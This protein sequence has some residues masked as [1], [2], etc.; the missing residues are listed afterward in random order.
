MDYKKLEQEY[1]K[2]NLERVSFSNCF[3][4]SN[5]ESTD[6]YLYRILNYVNDKMYLI[7]LSDKPFPYIDKSICTDEVWNSLDQILNL[8]LPDVVRTKLYDFRWLFYKNYESAKQAFEGYINLLE[9]ISVSIEND[10]LSYFC[11]VI[12]IC[13]SLNDEILIEKLKGKTEG[14]IE[15]YISAKSSP[16]RILLMIFENSIFNADEIIQLCEK[17]DK[18]EVATHEE[19]YRL[20]INLFRKSKQKNKDPEIIAVRRKIIELYE[21]LMS[22]DS[23]P[24]RKVYFTKEII[25]ELKEIPNTDNERSTWRKKLSEFQKDVLNNMFSSEFP[26]DVSKEMAIVEKCAKTDDCNEILHLLTYITSIPNYDTIKELVVSSVIKYPLSSLGI[27]NRLDDKGK[28]IA[29]MPRLNL[30]EPESDKNSL[31][32]H[33]CAELRNYYSITPVLYAPILEKIKD[34]DVKLA[35]N[36]IVNNC[37]F[38][39]KERKESFKIGFMAGFDGDYISALSVLIPQFEYALRALA[40]ELGGIVYTMESDGTE[41]VRTMEDVLRLPEIEETLEKDITVSMK[42]LFV[43]K[44][45]A[46]LRNNVAHGIINDENFNSFDCIYAWAFMFKLCYVWQEFDEETI[47]FRNH[48]D[49][50]FNKIFLEETD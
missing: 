29:I 3:D 20:K 8:K 31:D 41:R 26:I 12:S 22:K 42:A 5:E 50:K 47:L 32:A 23:S 39:P 43:S 7:D 9:T 46:N 38:I 6:Y 1:G 19:Y 37:F 10:F 18:T 33:V 28:T 25:K 36:K 16:Y 13:K 21:T 24:F 34:I 4:L 2:D 40:E 45:G 14:I 15:K 30:Q 27:N 44:Y 11:R 35:V 49:E 17:V 48:Q